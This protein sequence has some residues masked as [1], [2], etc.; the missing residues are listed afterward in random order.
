METP[1]EALAGPEHDGCYVHAHLV[2]QTLGK[3]LAT[4]LAGSDFDDAVTGE[5]PRPRHDRLARGGTEPHIFPDGSGI[6]CR[7]V[8]PSVRADAR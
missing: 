3:H 6:P 4:D 5:F 2:D 8:D 7:S 1:E